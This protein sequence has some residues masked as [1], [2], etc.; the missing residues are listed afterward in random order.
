MTCDR[1]GDEAA[2]L[3]LGHVA[4][5]RR[6][7][8]LDHAATCAPCG[9]L[10]ADLST[11]GD[12]LL[13]LAPEVDPPVGFEAGAVARMGAPVERPRSGGRLPLA[14]ALAAAAVV[15]ALLAGIAIGRGEIRAAGGDTVA[16]VVTR[17]G[18]RIGT[19]ELHP[20]ASRLI[21]TMDGDSNW[22]GT[23][24]CVVQDGSG[25][26]VEVGSWTADDVTNHVWAA[27]L[28]P[29]L[30]SARA[31]RILGDSGAVIASADLAE[32]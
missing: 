31:M 21:L 32:G 22:D 13:H 8:L 24:T 23:W 30:R 25:K 29:S 20:E 3:A 12:R 5:P 2:D 16:P 7:E 14:P 17:E 26:W 19:V 11:I 28:E 18:E 27:G 4:E 1:F 15:V 9:E 6:G 10:L